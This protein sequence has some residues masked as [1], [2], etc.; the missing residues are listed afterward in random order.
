LGW[1]NWRAGKGSEALR[2]LRGAVRSDPEDAEAHFLLSAAARAQALPEEAES[3]RELAVTLSPRLG[4]VDAS[5]VEGLERV[6]ER[7]RPLS[8]SRAS[9]ADDSGGSEEPE[10]EMLERAR[11][12]RDAGRLVD[13][14]LELQRVV[15]AQPHWV[16]ARVELAR[17]YRD[18]GELERAVGEFRVVLW[19]EESAA[20]HLQ[21]AELYLEMERLDEARVHVERALEL[22]PES[23]EAR[24]LLDRLKEPGE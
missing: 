19:D 7:L 16:E 2:A 12:Y 23:S 4:E 14:I 11:R 10:R 5:T 22:E 13:A 15:Y 20:T 6:E 21:L 8:G 17:T 3:E 24:S 18:S 1:A 9:P